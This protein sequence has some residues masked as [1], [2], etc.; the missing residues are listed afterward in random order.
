[1]LHDNL[2]INDAGHLCLAG[3]DTVSLAGEYGTPLYVLDEA[4]IRQ[5]MRVYADSISAFFPAGSMAL[6]ASKALSFREMYRI[7]REEGIGA[8]IVSGGEL[9][10]AL[11]AGFPAE[12]LYFHGSSKTEAEIRYAI[13]AGIGCFIVDNPE[14]LRRIS[15]CASE[16]GV[17]Q[18][19]LLRLT[20]G[21]DPHT[22]AAV[23]TGT[24]ES[25]FGIA[26]ETGQAVDFVRGAL[27]A[28]GVELCGYHCHIGSQ[29]AEAQPFFDTIDI[30]TAFIAR[31]RDELGYT[32]SVLNLGGGLAVPYFEGD[33]SADPAAV[34]PLVAAHLE[35]RCAALSLPVPA[36]LMEPGRSIVADA[37]LTLYTVQNIKSIPGY[38]DYV[39]V[40]GGMTDNP[41]YALYGSR[42]SAVIA[43][44][45]GEPA[46][47]IAS[48]AGR[49]CESDDLI[50]AEMPLQRPRIGDTLA[51]LVTGAY[52]YS[53][54]SHYNRVPKPPVVMLRDGQSR[55]V[56]RRE[57][58][59]DLVSCDI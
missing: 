8:D 36:V 53:M 21:I 39:A 58:Y 49:C 46:D 57:T 42:H 32:A 41:R 52:N 12:R 27:A 47:Y 1:M 35:T 31:M 11:S 59:E 40:D 38:A 10:T 48:V 22:F 28:P 7:A 44:R 16:K 9:Y 25:K 15:R 34:I 30:M 6:F 18:R 14:E 26:I 23:T 54:A 2:S 43:D 56:V 45:A 24:V 20:P 55:V 37:G 5:K 33:V 29:I 4:R 13:D 50:G 51:V 3:V 19:V 17:V